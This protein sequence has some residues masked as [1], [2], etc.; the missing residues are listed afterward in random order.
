M[1]ICP[2][3][4]QRYFDDAVN[5]GQVFKPERGRQLF[6]HAQGLYHGKVHF[7]IPVD[8]FQLR[9]EAGFVDNMLDSSYD[10]QPLFEGKLDLITDNSFHP[11]KL[12]NPVYF[13]ILNISGGW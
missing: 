1:F 6:D 4:L 11:V 13:A 12:Q 5:E 7:R 10:I 9:R 3:V 2:V 8:Q